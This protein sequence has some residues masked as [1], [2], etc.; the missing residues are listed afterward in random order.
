MAGRIDLNAGHGFGGAFVI[1]LPS[2]ETHHALILDGADNPAMFVGAL[3]ARV[4]IIAA[5]LE[6]ADRQGGGFGRR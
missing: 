2:G 3:S 1:V 5:E 4:G 6:N